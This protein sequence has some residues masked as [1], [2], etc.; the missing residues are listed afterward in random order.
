MAEGFYAVWATDRPGTAALRAELRPAHRAW[1]RDEAAHGV[2]VL[3]G[4]P[5]LDDAGAMNG[6]LLVVQAPDADL[7]RRFLERDPYTRGGLFAEASIRPWLCSL[8][9]N[10][11]D[12]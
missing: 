12:S 6:T 5:T 1:L 11:A 9:R 8:G 2:K 3:H 4:G 7:V 10:G